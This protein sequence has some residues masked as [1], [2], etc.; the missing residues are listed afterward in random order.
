MLFHVSD[1]LYQ[2]NAY[3]YPLIK[4]NFPELS[5]NQI[6]QIFDQKGVKLNDSIMN[7]NDKIDFIKLVHIS[8][9]HL[10]KIGK[11]RILVLIIKL[12]SLP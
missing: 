4:K 8:R 5:G 1:A 3:L 9:D 11:N 10:V 7:F 12:V 2:A 6:K